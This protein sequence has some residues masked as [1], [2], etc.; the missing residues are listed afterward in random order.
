M[1]TNISVVTEVC[2]SQVNLTRVSIAS[3]IKNNQWFDGKI[4]LLCARNLPVSL[5]S[6]QSIRKIYD[7]VEVMQLTQIDDFASRLTERKI[8]LSD[9]NLIQLAYLEILRSGLTKFLYFSNK[10]L[11]LKDVSSILNKN[12][13][14]IDSSSRMFY[15]GSDEP[16]DLTLVYSNIQNSLSNNLANVF[17]PRLIESIFFS[18]F[19]KNKAITSNLLMDFSSNYKNANPHKLASFTNSAACILYDT[20]TASTIHY[21]KVNNIW[22]S[23]HTKVSQTL[24]SARSF[25]H[26]ILSKEL[27]N[28]PNIKKSEPATFPEKYKLAVLIHC[29]YYEIMPE[30]KQYV[31]NLPD[32]PDVFIN[33]PENVRDSAQI[34]KVVELFPNAKIHFSENRG[35]DI[36]GFISLWSTYGSKEYTSVLLLHTKKSPH[37]QNGNAWRKDLLRSILGDSRIAR[38]NAASIYPNSNIGIIGSRQHRNKNLGSNGS[39]VAKLNKL[40]EI[41][42]RFATIDYVSGTIMFISPLILD[43]L[44]SKLKHSDFTECTDKS[45]QYH[46]D[47]QLEHAVERFLAIL[48]RKLGK[49]IKYI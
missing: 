23:F 7:N 12:E 4:Y 47:G 35:R 29:Y 24:N 1:S 14:T 22:L 2:D 31:D 9:D 46:M 28:F 44:C 6:L 33:I 21:S 48:C 3:F 15:Y 27:P 25:N 39:N 45:L 36:G 32:N 42:S 16:A 11:F 18:E 5:A 13:I 37:L 30:L 41:P 20:L 40:F 17:R 10:C 43:H 38:T 8:N 34:E 19:S 26:Q 49:V